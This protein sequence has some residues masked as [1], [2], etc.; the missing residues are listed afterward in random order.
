MGILTRVIVKISANIAALWIAASYVEGFILAGGIPS[1]II[2]G[3]VLAGINLVVRPILKLVSL[4]FLVVTLGAFF[5]V[6]FIIIL[7][8]A[9]F[10][11]PQLTING[12]AAIL[13]G[14]MIIGLINTIVR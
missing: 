8:I 10:L 4:P 9:D 13:W 12:F 5:I 7:L 14:A 3:T 1:F 6:I 11:L 2:G